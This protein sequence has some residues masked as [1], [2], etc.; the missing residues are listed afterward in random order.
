MTSRRGAIEIWSRVCAVVMCASGTF[1]LEAQEIPR[2]PEVEYPKYS[3]QADDLVISRSTYHEKLQG[4]WLGECVANWTGLRT[5]GV[6]KTA[7][8]FTDKSWGFPG[9]DLR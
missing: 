3:C 1:G 2:D 5:E 7:P 6:K 9:E 4:F 8:F